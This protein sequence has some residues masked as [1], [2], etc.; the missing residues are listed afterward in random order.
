MNPESKDAANR[1][2]V[3]IFVYEANPATRQ[4]EQLSF[5]LARAE[6][7][8]IVVDELAKQVKKDAK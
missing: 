6:D 4:Y 3:P 1:R 5:N 8:R 2:A 7:E